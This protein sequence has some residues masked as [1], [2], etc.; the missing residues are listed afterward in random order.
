MEMV[1]VTNNS[2]GTTLITINRPARK[3]AICAITAREL[4]QAFAEFDQS[5]QRVAVLTG[6]GND[7]F[8]AGADVTNLPELWRCV[9]TVGITTE[10]PVIAA[11]GGWC[12]G[13]ALVVAMMC[14]LLVTADNGKFSYPEAKLGFT[15]GLISALPTR[16][17]HKIAMELIMLCRTIDAKRAYDVGF[18][19]EVVPVGQQVEAALAMARELATFAP[20][21]LRTLKRFVV[22]DVMPQ[23]P[24][25]K[26]GRAMRDLGMVRDSQDGQE[27]ARAFKEKRAPKWVGR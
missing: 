18:A 20:L 21:V 3:N 9:P 13:G 6:A 25:E 1:Q 2:D 11:V 24:S 17:P 4:Q 16:I 14:D 23:G 19:N 5:E 8:S 12:V 15:G 26:M 27:G 7:A 22:D 10:K